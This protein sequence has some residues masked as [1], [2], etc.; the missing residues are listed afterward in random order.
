MG[1]PFSLE[2]WSP[3][4]ACGGCGSR[5]VPS[6]SRGSPGCLP[7][8]QGMSVS[9]FG[10]SVGPSLGLVLQVLV[11]LLYRE[12]FLGRNS[13]CPSNLQS[14]F[15]PRGG[16]CRSL[17][18]GLARRSVHSLCSWSSVFLYQVT[19]LPPSP[20]LVWIFQHA[21]RP[22]FKS[23]TPELR[24]VYPSPPSRI[25][26]AEVL[27]ILCSSVCRLHCTDRPNASNIALGNCWVQ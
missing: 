22:P 11:R 12:F 21:P 13:R 14:C 20:C 18:S 7:S 8:R 4:S 25:V 6:P 3:S 26:G 10:L 19:A 5:S 24:M 16:G 15:P 23:F 1:R 27:D 2:L 17:P 9:G